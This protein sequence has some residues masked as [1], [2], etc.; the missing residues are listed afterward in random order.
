MIG[1]A[2]KADPALHVA[3]QQNASRKQWK[4]DWLTVAFMEFQIA[5]GQLRGWDLDKLVLKGFLHSDDRARLSGS[6]YVAPQSAVS[7]K[8]WTHE[9]LT[10][11][12]RDE[13]EGK[14]WH[15]FFA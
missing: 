10:F 13:K 3:T 5:T 2:C 6:I 14:S 8:H 11:L 7:R 15:H 12:R 4:L 9:Q 1:L